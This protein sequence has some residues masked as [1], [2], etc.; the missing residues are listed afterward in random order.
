VREQNGK[1]AMPLN[2]PADSTEKSSVTV[3]SFLRFLRSGGDTGKEEN[4]DILLDKVQKRVESGDELNPEHREKI[5]N[6]AEKCSLSAVQRYLRVLHAS[7]MQLEAFEAEGAEGR[8]PYLAI[9]VAD[10]AA[11]QRLAEAYRTMFRDEERPPFELQPYLASDFTAATP[12]E[13][14]TRRSYRAVLAA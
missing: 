2:N 5:R 3:F 7:G 1:D 8:P 10:R 9:V 4:L 11:I 14:F 13:A 6:L 12:E